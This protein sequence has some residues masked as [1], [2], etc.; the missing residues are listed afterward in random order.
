M[1]YEDKI[2]LKQLNKNGYK[3]IDLFCGGGLG[4]YGI[5]KAGFDIVYA[6]DINKYAVDTYN[7][8]IGNHCIKE[9]IRKLS[10]DDI[11]DCDIV[12]A[13]P[14]CKSF[15]FAGNRKGFSDDKYGDLPY[16]FVRV[17][18]GKKP[19]A[20]VFE[21]VKG[22]LSKSSKDEFFNLIRYLKGLGYNIKHKLIN[23]YLYGVPQLRER[24]IMVGIRNDIG[25]FEFPLE[26]DESKRLNIYEAIGDLPNPY[27]VM[28]SKKDIQYISNKEEVLI[29]NHIG[30]GL[31]NDEKNFI[32]KVPSGGNWRDLNE[33]E[34]KAFLGKAYFN[35]GGR[36]GYLRKV[37]I[38]NPAHTITSSMLGKN[39][40]QII[41]NK[42]IEIYE[43]KINNQN[44]YYE[45]G[46]SSMYLNRNRQKQWNEP[47]YTIV[48]EARH[49]PL[50]PEP[51]NF[52]IR[53]INE[54]DVPPPRRFT[55]RECLRLQSVPDDF[56]IDSDI[57]LAKQYEIVGNGIPSLITYKVFKELYN[58]LENKS[59]H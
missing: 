40:A 9:D 28:N 21:N 24:V 15:S 34:A 1:N 53:K 45:G 41:D 3:V 50:Y 8:N 22:I 55:V 7:K 51:M 20:F 52:D 19:K 37:N 39:N 33:E 59:N 6:I 43:H 56:V 31:R 17:V 26:V 10:I 48:S 18:E 49:L 42:D 35:S 2:G 4:A 16:Q 5:K 46:Y 32:N 54:Y 27:M 44:I 36:T 38:D 29:N 47:S 13:S 12:M 57:S 23:C 11:P 14:V 58:I 30:Y 25:K